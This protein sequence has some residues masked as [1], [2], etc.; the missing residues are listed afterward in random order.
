MPDLLY[1]MPDPEVPDSD[2]LGYGDLVYSNGSTEYLSGDPEIAMGL[3]RPPPGVNPQGSIGMG[4]P[5]PPPQPQMPEPAVIDGPQ[6]PVQVGMDGSLSPVQPEQSFGAGNRSLGDLFSGLDTESGA[7]FAPQGGDPFSMPAAAPQ[8]P[9]APQ[10][11]GQGGPPPVTLQSETGEPFTIDAT[12]NIQPGA[13]G[14]PIEQLQ[15]Q[16]GGGMG[17]GGGMVPVER[18]GALPPDVAQ[19]QLGALDASQQQTLGLTEQARRDESRM[20]AEL[21]MQQLAQNEAQRIQREEEIA[22][23]QAKVQRW[24]QEQQALTDMEIETDLVSAKGAV[25]AVFAVLGAALLG[26][27]GNDAGLRMIESSIDRHVRQQVSRRDTKLGILSNQIGSSMQAV[28]LGKA[29]LYKVAADRA[30]LLAQK[31]KNDVYEAQSPAVI[32]QLRQKQLE[33]LQAAEQTSMGKLIER[34]PPP[35]KP[36]SEASLQK[37]GELRRDRD[38]T[39]S[40]AQRAEREI[41]LRWVPG[42]SGEPGHYQ[43]PDG[44]PLTPD[45]IGKV[46]IQGI[47]NL[48]QWVPDFVY[49]TMGGTT[50]EGYQVR[51]AAQAMA[52]AQIR[53]MQPTGPISN[54]DIQAAVK[55]G[56]LDTEGGMLKAITRIRSDAE[57]QRQHD[58][59]QFGPDVVGEYE[60]RFQAGGGDQGGA[61]AA[62]RRPSIESAR[63]AAAALR[64]QPEAAA[65]AAGSVET[66]SAAALMEPRDRMAQVAEDVQ[67]LAGEELPPEGLAILVAQAAHE[68]GN[69]DSQGAA[70]GNMFG[71]KRTG[72]RAGITANTTEG[73]GAGAHRTRA[74]FALYPSISDGVADHLSLIK[75]KYPRGWEALQ[76]GDVAAYVAAL[77][78]GGYF[79]G[80]ESIYANSL[81]R[82]L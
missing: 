43:G 47:G 18:Q 1:F 5:A 78:D 62:S 13:G 41:G 61:P 46:G 28:S 4:P 44:T 80:N 70:A 8:Q 65:P 64:K 36:P 52:Y 7:A 74:E 15:Q 67:V 17:G 68:S 23:E 53:Q 26:G 40:I 82:M 24:Q 71:H 42:A 72:K 38:A 45:N 12:G 54:A 37:Y 21:T 16:M 6:G 76:A 77:K 33:N 22:T 11:G 49:S 19:R 35:P 34:V 20:M 51:G 60:R 3:P 2:M 63:S 79:T 32:Q 50:A 59:A 81:R 9:G 29:A 48:E 75:R 10:G 30:E 66:E 55:A 27:A 73:E 58:A 56:A 39:I 31:T 25:G 69:G 57:R 14:V